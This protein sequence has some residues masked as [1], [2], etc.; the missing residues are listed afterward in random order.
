MKYVFLLILL[1]GCLTM[2]AK[3]EIERLHKLSE[4][5]IEHVINETLAESGVTDAILS[6]VTEPD[7]HNWMTT[8]GVGLLAA[9]SSRKEYCERKGKAESEE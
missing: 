7:W 4:I 5:K 1:P 8:V 6:E 2:G 3:L 9:W